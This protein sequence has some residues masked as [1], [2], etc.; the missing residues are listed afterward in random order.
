[1]F[2]TL[3]TKSV[4]KWT[5]VIILDLIILSGIILIASHYYSI[6]SPNIKISGVYLNKPQEISEFALT[7]QH[8]Q[9]FTKN[10][11]HNH[12][13]LLFFGFTHCPMICPTTLDALQKMYTLVEKQ[14]PSES[15]PQIVFISIDPERDTKERLKEYINRFNPNFIAARTD[16]N[17]TK[18]I[19]KQF[20]IAVENQSGTFNHSTD[21]LLINPEAK[22]QAYFL[23]PQRPANLAEDY[24]RIVES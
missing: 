16:T 10:Q 4:H 18:S 19:L 14:L 23:F 8:G 2:K 21:V 20:S 3:S 6:Y 22:I 24:K 17:N 1:M 12:W 7:D 5:R 13:T 9:A 11:L 15:L